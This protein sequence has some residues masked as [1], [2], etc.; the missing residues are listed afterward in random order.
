MIIPSWPLMFH[1]IIAGLVSY[2]MAP[3]HSAIPF[4]SALLI[5]LL[6]GFVLSAQLEAGLVTAFLSAFMIGL[7]DTIK[8]DT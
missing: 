8:E 6:T 7:I 3:R 5:W 2:L 4:A 1:V